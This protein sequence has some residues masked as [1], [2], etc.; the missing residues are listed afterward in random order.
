MPA[1]LVHGNPESAAIWDLLIPELDRNDVVALSPPG[2]GAPCPP[3]WSA[4]HTEYRLWLVSELESIDEPVDLLGHDWGGVHALGVVLT[5]PDLIRSW[6]TDAA[7][8]IHPD[9]VWHDMAQVWQTE[10]AGEA[11]IEEMLIKPSLEE[12]TELLAGLGMAHPVAVKV[13]Q[14]FDEEMAR[15]I[16]ALLRSAAQPAMAELGADLNRARERP[17]L[18]VLAEEDPYVGTQAMARSQAERMGASFGFLEAVGHWWMTQDP[19]SG[20]AMLN[21]FWSSL[22]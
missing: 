17:G 7:G 14:E 16:L 20:A 19:R 10:G 11:A 1:V 22:D 6:A 15:C 13:A 5:R 9:Y 4:T 12:K 2:F 18:V 3:G 21:R 8:V